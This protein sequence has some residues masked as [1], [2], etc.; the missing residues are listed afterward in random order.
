MCEAVGEAVPGILSSIA[1]SIAIAS[2]AIDIVPALGR[3]TSARFLFAH[4]LAAAPEGARR[5]VIRPDG[6]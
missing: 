3:S 2:R 4:D 5:G 1:G 6:A